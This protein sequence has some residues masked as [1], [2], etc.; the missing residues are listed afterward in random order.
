MMRVEVPQATLE[1]TREVVDAIAAG[2]RC[3]ASISAASGVALRQVSYGIAS[4]RVLGLVVG[5]ESF[6]LTALGREV[7]AAEAGHDAELAALRRAVEASLLLSEVAPGLLATEPPPR[8]EVIRRI[9]EHAGL[10]ENTAAHRAGMLFGWRKRLLEAPDPRE[11]KERLLGGRWRR[12]DVTNLRSLE[13]LSL[14]FG[15]L[16]V[17]HGPTASGKSNIV[18]ALVLAHELGVEP[19]AALARRGGLAAVVRFGRGP[20]VLEQRVAAT[21][22]ALEHSYRRHRMVIDADD[23]WSIL[24]ETW[25]VAHQGERLIDAWREGVAARFGESAEILERDQALLES[26]L[27]QRALGR[28]AALKPAMRLRLDVERMRLP[29][30]PEDV[31][32]QPDGT[33]LAAAVLRL[34]ESRSYPGM[35]ET[36]RNIVPGLVDFVG[37]R[38]AAGKVQLIATQTL[39]PGMTT[40]LPMGAWSRG[41]QLA[42]GALVAALQLVADELLVV[43]LDE[44]GLDAASLALVIDAFEAASRRA[45]VVLTTSDEELAQSIGADVHVLCRFRAGR[46]EAAA[47]GLRVV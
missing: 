38:D 2:A 22:D 9:R 34:Q 35:L 30:S 26:P 18:D 25:Q 36:L 41:T 15:P 4:A 20:L 8:E 39:G 12:I 44:F 31:R 11:V 24:E 43:E 37:E 13:H 45:T 47:P 7:A 6:E 28:H 17:V 1:R 3:R 40:R 16:S 29:C 42:L 23:A 46:T 33:N 21:R 10:A 27:G 19:R 5:E 14:D 32:M